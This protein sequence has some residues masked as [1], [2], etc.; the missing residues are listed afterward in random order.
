MDGR[1]P[2]TL[3][4]EELDHE[5]AA[6]IDVAPSPEFLARVRTRI[7]EEPMPQGRRLMPWP[8]WASAAAVAAIAIPIVVTSLMDR[9]ERPIAPQQPAAAVPQEDAVPQEYVAAGPGKDVAADVQVRQATGPGKDVAAG[10]QARNAPSSA[11]VSSDL[12]TPPFAEV[13]VPIERRL[14][15]ERLVDAVE[16]G[17]APAF[18]AVA[19]DPENPF[20]IEPLDI[21]PLTL[22][23]LAIGLPAS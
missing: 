6:A 13:L 1:Q 11:D 14:A 18:V 8:T 5:L 4:D 15:F 9:A 22:T 2:R 16:R 7:A 20:G 17:R 19:A 10:L 3:S 21:E 12:D 23:D